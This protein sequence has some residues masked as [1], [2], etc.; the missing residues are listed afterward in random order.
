MP[1]VRR[2]FGKSMESSIDRGMNLQELFARAPGKPVSI[3][4]QTVVQLDRIPIQRG[5]VEVEFTSFIAGQ[6]IQLAATKGKIWLSDGRTVRRV[7]ILAHPSL[8]NTASHK[9]S[10]PEGELCVYNVYELRYTSGQPFYSMWSGNAGMIVEEVSPFVRA[11]RC[12]QGPGEFS[13]SD[14]HFAL[15]WKPA[16]SKR[17]G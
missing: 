15:R 14:L 4:G 7:N 9:V 12:S 3:G 5:I 16:D 8:P 6:G 13:P 2:R 17:R 10:C 1:G 11:Y